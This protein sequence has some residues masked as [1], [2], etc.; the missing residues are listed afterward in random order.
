[1]EESIVRPNPSIERT[2]LLSERK[3]VI[4]RMWGFLMV[5]TLYSVIA[6]T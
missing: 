5:S 6:Y 4:K 3:I 1:M 2:Y